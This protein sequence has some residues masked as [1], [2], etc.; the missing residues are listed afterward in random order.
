MNPAEK[1]L[2][3]DD[4]PPILELVT[5]NLEREGFKTATARDGEEG[6]AVFRRF[7]PDLVI[8][9][10]MLPGLGGLEVCRNL[11]MESQVPIIMLTARQ[12]E[13]DR[14]LGLELGADDYVTKPFSPRELVARVRAILRRAARTGDDGALGLGDLRIDVAARQVYLA[15][16]PVELTRTEFELLLA[17]AG[18]PG[19]VWGREALLGQVWGGEFFGDPR[20]VDVHIRHLREKLKENPAEPRYLET[21]RGF[22]YRFRPP[23]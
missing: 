11:R 7:A 16:E 5:F 10:L 2:V 8:L 13:V 22:G 19:R 21:V 6:L 23:R 12:D 20:T 17:L 15:E 3:I 1:V 18:S 4:E 14:V 9:D